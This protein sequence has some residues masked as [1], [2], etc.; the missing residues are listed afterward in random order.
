MPARPSALARRRARYAT[1][2]TP[3]DATPERLAEEIV[4]LTISDDGLGVSQQSN[5]LWTSRQ[6]FQESRPLLERVGAASLN[7]SLAATLQSLTAVSSTSS[8]S[9]ARMPAPPPSLP[10]LDEQ[11]PTLSTTVED[12]LKDDI[13]QL[14]TTSSSSLPI[15]TQPPSS[16]WE[17]FP[18]STS[19]QQQPTRTPQSSIIYDIPDEKQLPR[20]FPRRTAAQKAIQDDLQMAAGIGSDLDDLEKTI[21][22]KPTAELYDQ[23]R[24]QLDE[25]RKSIGLLTRQDPRVQESG[26]CLHA[27]CD[28]I[29]ETLTTW[30]AVIG[31]P[32]AP[33]VVDTSKSR[34]SLPPINVS[35]SC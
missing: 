14:V 26:E 20:R 32:D 29:C 7:E 9:P 15:L 13:P 25:A 35:P 4:G 8:F 31:L 21:A 10:R 5:R 24:G 19:A 2:A 30:A 3:Q 23:L 16:E 12:Y 6:Q 11:R 33:R 34:C 27:R 22:Q 1:L 28:R 18:P 17:S